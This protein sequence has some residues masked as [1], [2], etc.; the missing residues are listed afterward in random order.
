MAKF[1]E[2]AQLTQ[3]N[4]VA[5]MDID[6]GRVDAVFHSQRLAR[7]DAFFELF[8]HLPGRHDIVDAPSENGPLFLGAER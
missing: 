4:R 8:L 2:L 6:S 1:L 3:G 5:E 7:G